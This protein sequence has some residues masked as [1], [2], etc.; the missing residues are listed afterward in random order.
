[1]TNRAR[2]ALH[3]WPDIRHTNPV[4]QLLGR[5]ASLRLVVLI[6]DGVSIR[7]HALMQDARDE[8]AATLLAAEYDVLAM[9]MTAQSRANV[10]A[11]S[12]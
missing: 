6:V 4:L 12:A 5:A 8:N 9:L 11:K 10:I 2:E 1:V 3:K 7:E